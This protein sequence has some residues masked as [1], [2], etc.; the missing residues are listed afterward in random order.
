M[1]HPHRPADECRLGASVGP[2]SADDQFGRQA[3]DV[4]N[5]LWGV[6][7]DRCPQLIEPGRIAVDVVAI[8]Q[9]VLHHDVNETVDEG[10]VRSGA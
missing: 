7:T 2:G 3:G 1:I 6:F 9:V 8:D 5:P 4:R 10:K